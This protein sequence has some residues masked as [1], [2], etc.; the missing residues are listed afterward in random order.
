MRVEDKDFFGAHG[1]VYHGAW[2]DNESA[3]K[4]AEDCGVDLPYCFFQTSNSFHGM[5]DSWKRFPRNGTPL[6]PGGNFSVR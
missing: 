2:I 3:L 1:E 5:D 6:G 4:R